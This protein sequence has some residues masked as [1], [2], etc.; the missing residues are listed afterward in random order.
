LH[1]AVHQ[2]TISLCR[3]SVPLAVYTLRHH[4]ANTCSVSMYYSAENPKEDALTSPFV[5]H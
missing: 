3:I 1:I 2:Q 5:Y 4:K